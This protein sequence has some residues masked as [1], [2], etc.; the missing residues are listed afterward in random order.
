MVVKMEFPA[1]VTGVPEAISVLALI[2]PGPK[3]PDQT[4]VILG[5]NASLFKRLA[6]L[7]KETTGVYFSQTL[8]FKASCV[9]P[10]TNPAQVEEDVGSVQWLGLKPLTL[11]P[12]SRRCID[13]H[14]ELKHPF[15]NEMLMVEASDTDPLPA[16]VFLEPV[17]V[18]KAAI[19][20][21]RFPVHVQNESQRE[22]NLPVG[23]LMRCV[24]PVDPVVP[25]PD[26][27]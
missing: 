11:P 5:T 17:V 8:G 10:P 9:K 3:S 13:C 1:D 23:N 4:Q 12:Q 25:V 19:Q 7:C 15:T 22:V 18:S 2:C 24:H 20:I 26:S 14:V 16:G 6:S 21:E 27:L